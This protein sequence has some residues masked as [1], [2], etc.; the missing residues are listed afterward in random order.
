MLW[1]PDLSNTGTSVPEIV[2]HY[3]PGATLTEK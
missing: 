1:A 3:D 2:E